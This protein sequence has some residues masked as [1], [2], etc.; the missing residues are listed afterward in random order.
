MPLKIHMVINK[1][2]HAVIISR[3][4][5]EPLSVNVFLAG[6]MTETNSFSN[7]PTSRS[8]FM[9]TA[10]A[11]GLDAALRQPLF[12]PL[13][14]GLVDGCRQLGHELVCGPLAFAQPGGPTVQADYEVLRE[15]VLSDLR[16][17]MPVAGVL[18]A[19]HGAMVAQ[20][21]W[22]C[23]GDLLA[24][25]RAL[26]GPEVPIVSVLDPHAHLSEAMVAHASLMAFMKEYPHTDG[27]QR[28]ADV[29]RVLQGI[30]NHGVTPTAA[31]VDCR[32][33]GHWPT[34][35]EPIRTLTDRFYAAE[36]RPGVLSASF[37]HGFPWGDTPE[38]G[39]KV[40]VYTDDDPTLAQA[41]AQELAAEVI[42]LREASRVA[43][44]PIA[45]ALEI[46]ATSEGLTVIADYADNPSG[47]A[48]S[49]AS[50]ILRDVLGRGLKQV[51]FG[52]FYDPE[53]V[54]AAF[55]VGIGSRLE[56]RLGGKT[57]R[58]SGEPVDFIGT[59][60]GLRRDATQ[61][62]FGQLRDRLGDIAWLHFDGLDVVISSV[63]AQC[64]DPAPFEELGLS[65]SQQRAVVVKSSNHFHHAFAPLARRVLIVGD[66]GAL[67]TDFS[68]IPYRHLQRPRWPRNEAVWP[69]AEGSL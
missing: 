56:G 52:W 18:L 12:A 55:A 2:N 1:Y 15:E 23:E 17:A 4:W 7:I 67:T 64:H 22:D 54:K 51:A 61:L 14:R 26:V 60:R 47:G 58:F 69:N 13:V 5:P 50:Y 37:V 41:V 6:L 66:R 65:L 53:L 46:A 49:D 10:Y 42:A 11:R 38:T 9:E 21:C 20:D 30:R 45:E 57:G 25:V 34:Q 19:L 3:N 16:Q 59:V 62:M 40:L 63:R 36:Q 48:P 44:T 39:S 8:S 31:V 24:R 33:L 43:T 29:L 32:L 28:W 35:A 68:A 27:P